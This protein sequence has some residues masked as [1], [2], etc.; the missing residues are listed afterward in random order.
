MRE[1]KV[2][3]RIR[4]YML[5]YIEGCGEAGLR[6][7]LTG[8]RGY[9][10]AVLGP[11]LVAAGHNVV[12]LDNLYFDDGNIESEP[13]GIHTIRKDIRDLTHED[14]H[15]VDS[16]IHL[17]GL[18]NDPLGDLDA[19]LTYQINHH[20]TIPLARIARD[21]GVERF[22]YASSCSMYG[23][24]GEGLVGEDAPLRPLTAYATSKARAEEGLSNV[25]DK[26]FSPVLMRNATAYGA[27]PR[28]R[29]DLVLNNLVCWAY[30]TGEVRLTSDGTPWRP[31]AHV[32]DLA[33]AFKI[34]LTGPRHLVHNQ[35]F[36]VGT[37]GENYRVRDLAHI[38]K[39]TIPGSSV[40]FGNGNTSDRRSYRVDFS[41]LTLTL[42]EFEPRWNARLGAR[43]LYE[44]L[45]G[46]ALRPRDF[47]GP[48]YVRLEKLMHLLAEGRLGTDLRWKS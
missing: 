13:D 7:L 4:L 33:Q 41:K 45:R 25:A 17:A 27:S 37:P 5:S 21:V 1:I 29:S 11:V 34:A 18:S 23:A 16:V 42:Q 28:L 32:E 15:D 9:I 14:L 22:L 30:A 2:C 20:A 10:G 38:V 26:D 39:E 8:N 3:E 12:G 24:A 35:A 19:N 40:A 47:Q 36:N 6:V 31:L 44:H 48:G 43:Q 46:S